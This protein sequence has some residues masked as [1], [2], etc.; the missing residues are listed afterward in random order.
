MRIIGGSHKSRIIKVLSQFKDRP[1]T[2]FA[3]ESLF[4]VLNNTYYFEDLTVL[5]L[6]AGSGSIGFE[7]AS[8]GTKSITSVDS[9]K[10]Y[11]DFIKKQSVEIFGNGIFQVINADVF[12]FLK[13]HPLNYD[14]I[15]ADP[16]YKIENIDLLP[17]LV[18]EN[19]YLNNDSLFILEH[20]KYINFEQHKYFQKEKIYGYVHF[21]FFSKEKE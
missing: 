17:D 21:S 6:F 8:R 10:L 14:V 13:K 2:D 1:T 9:N 11:S 4:N 18:F 5:D 3:K 12:D 7:F 15:F 19:K 16:P 20:S